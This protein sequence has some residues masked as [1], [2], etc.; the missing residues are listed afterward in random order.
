MRN[1]QQL[2]RE[3][4]AITL[5]VRRL[6]RAAFFAMRLRAASYLGTIAL[7][8]R[9]ATDSVR[10]CRKCRV[11]VAARRATLHPTPPL[12]VPTRCAATVRER[13]DAMSAREQVEPFC[14]HWL[15]RPANRAPPLAAAP[16]E[17]IEPQLWRLRGVEG[18][19]RCELPGEEERERTK[20]RER[21][22]ADFL[23]ASS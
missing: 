4:R 22:A 21:L 9:R 19:H 15:P 6:G 18:E 20:E 8:G 23:V 1:G 10:R 14:A 16:A 11:K 7:R 12:L 3:A 13:D 2:S 17:I 5:V